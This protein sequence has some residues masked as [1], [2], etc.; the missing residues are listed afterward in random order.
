M[1]GK[2]KLVQTNS[3]TITATN[4]GKS[5]GVRFYFRWAGDFIVA[6]STR[7]IINCGDP[8]DR[9]ARTTSKTDDTGGYAHVA[10]P[11]HSN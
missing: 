10:I 7:A 1:Q 6:G 2:K 5:R 11:I 4:A 9:I 8:N 3:F